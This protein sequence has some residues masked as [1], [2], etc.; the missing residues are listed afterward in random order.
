MPALMLRCSNGYNV[1]SSSCR[2]LPTVPAQCQEGAGSNLYISILFA[3]GALRPVPVVSVSGGIWLSVFRRPE[4]EAEAAKAEAALAAKARAAAAVTE[5][6]Q[7]VHKVAE[8]FFANGFRRRVSVEGF[9][10]Q[11]L[12][13]NPMFFDFALQLLSLA[14]VHDFG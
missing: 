11:S 10:L 14:F 9:C 2:I 3:R 6:V 8:S 4:I 13:L 7:E 5:T 12:C 1:F